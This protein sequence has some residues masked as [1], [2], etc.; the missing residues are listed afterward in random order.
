LSATIL[1]LAVIASE[2]SG[3][4]AV[5]GNL[6][7]A[8]THAVS[9]RTLPGIVDV[10]AKKKHVAKK[11]QRA[12]AKVTHAKPAAHAKAKP[13][14]ASDEPLEVRLPRSR[15][16][17]EAVAHASFYGFTPDNV[18]KE[19]LDALSDRQYTEAR[20]L[21]AGHR[22]PVAIALVDWLVAREPDSGLSAPQ[23]LAILQSHPGWPEPDRLRLR[24]EQAFHATGPDGAAI[25]TFYSVAPP[26]S[27]GGR[28]AL[29]GAL[30]EAGRESESLPIV[31]E[32][33]RE[34]S[35]T[36]NQAATLLTRF[37]DDLSRD[38]HL[39]RF[40]RLVLRG[41]ITEA[42][43]EAAFL[44]PGYKDLALAVDAALDRRS[45]AKRLL[46]D[47]A[48]GFFA[49]PLYVFAQVRLLRR[50]G[51]PIEAA[52]LILKTKPD[53]TLAGDADVWW[54]ER[55]DLSRALLDRDTPDLAY[56]V[57]AEAHATGDGERVEAAFHAGWYA[58]RFL[59][60]PD[61]A[62]THFRELVTLATLPRTRSRAYYW[63]GRTLD[64]EDE[65]EPAHGAYADAA[66][67]GGTF[68]G[69]LAREKMGLAT[70]GM[71]R[72]PVP[73][74]LDR[75]RFADRDCV[76]AIRLLAAAG[77]SERAFPFFREVAESVRT[78]GEVALLTALAR[79][80]K[81]PRAGVQAAAIAEQR[82]LRVASLPA[83][84]LG[85][86][87]GISLPDVVDRALVYAVVRQESAFNHQATSSAGA[88]GLMQLMPGTAQIT[89]RNAQLPFSL[90]RLTSDPHYNATLG[91][92]HLGDLLDRLNSSY[93]LTFVGYN[94]GPG[95][96]KQWVQAYGDPRGGAVD[97][98]DWIERIPFD[99]TRN[100]V[101]KVMENLQVYRSRIGHPL[102]LSQDLARGGPQG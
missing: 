100:Y 92:Q 64:A 81:Q 102:S 73:S 6:G 46:H 91:A 36:P 24:I 41:S 22:D 12:H 84:F 60:R 79:R 75:L 86:P 95:R 63:L 11:T 82:G 30:K 7:A 9:E 50:S 40:R 71:E 58:L 97:P 59:Q 14:P 49:D 21:V 68:Y 67:Y 61:L 77:Y 99:E 18:L 10:K 3:A 96:A 2:P 17:P 78:P 90:Q 31:R 83:P 80:I 26:Q 87:T 48:P 88:R 70:T 55:R 39:Y 23:I 53:A 98:V 85:V 27:V 42:S 34:Q 65:A 62:E 5:M 19:A 15:P 66:Q 101:Q 37:G 76:R 89:A 35:L 72:A 29:A 1:A 47:V 20:A 28:L 16:D 45:E 38:D 25:L 8:T 57:V 4:A 54:D 52:Q 69:Q 94:A 33:W 56:Q 32:L 51:E 13:A 44:G 43:R 93:V 74:A